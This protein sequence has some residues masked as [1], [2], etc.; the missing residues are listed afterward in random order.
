MDIEEFESGK[1]EWRNI[2]QLNNYTIDR[3]N[4]KISLKIYPKQVF[5]INTVDVEKLERQRDENVR[6]KYL[7]ITGESGEI[8]LQ[9]NQVFNNFKPEM[10]DWSL[11]EKNYPTYIYYYQ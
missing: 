10:R 11:L 9:G 1:N 6:V 5:R 2:D 8:K 4:K 7:K 3:E